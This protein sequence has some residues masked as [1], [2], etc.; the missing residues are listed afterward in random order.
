VRDGGR[1]VRDAAVHLSADVLVDALRARDLLELVLDVCRAR[2]V[3]LHDLCGR[4][5]SQ[6]VCRARHEVWWC[7][8]HHPERSYSLGEIARLFGRD[9]STVFDGVRA[10]GRHVSS[11]ADPPSEVI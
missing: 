5:R 4:A 8:R 3:L 2:G 10:H 1:V 6:S 11:D 7:I 9:P